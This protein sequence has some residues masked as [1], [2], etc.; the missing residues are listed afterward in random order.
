MFWLFM[1]HWPQ[2]KVFRIEMTPLFFLLP[3]ASEG[4]GCCH[5]L[6][7]TKECL[8][9]SWRS[10]VNGA[11]DIRREIPIGNRIANR[12]FYKW[13]SVWFKEENLEA[14]SLLLACLSWVRE[15]WLNV[16]V[17]RRGRNRRAGPSVEGWSSSGCRH[18]TL[19]PPQ[20]SFWVPGF[21][22]REPGGQ[23]HELRHQVNSLLHMWLG[24]SH[25]I[26]QSF[27]FLD[28]EMRLIKHALLSCKISW[29]NECGAFFP[30]PGT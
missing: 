25:L 2:L 15:R 14:R 24:T 23:E 26:S 22:W 7:G 18:M 6:M 8:G 29:D 5:G 27:S 3:W 13:E 1:M 10:P 20:P 12:R 28:C 4:W 19:W 16:G 21:A 9:G 17:R 30:V 11:D